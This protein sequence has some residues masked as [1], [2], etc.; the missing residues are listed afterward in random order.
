M[1]DPDDVRQA[2]PPA[3]RLPAPQ[4]PALAAYRARN[5][6]AMSGYAAIL[7]L[8]V[9]LVFVGVKL[10]YAH[11]ELNQV[12]HATAAAPAP[13]PTASTAG[14]LSLQWRTTDHPSGGNPYSNGIV[15]TY[16]GHTVNGRDALTGAVRWHYT[17]ADED[18]C[19]L[20]QQ[21][22]STI[23]FY[24]RDGNCDEVTGFVTATGV[25]K[26]YRT[27]TDNGPLSVSS[28]SNVVMITSARTVHVFDN[29]GGIDR[30]LWTAPA[31]CT[32][33]RALGG[34]SGVLFSYHCGSQNHLGLH[35]LVGGDENAKWTIDVSEPYVPV[36]AGAIVAAAAAS[37]GQVTVFSTDKGVAGKKFRLTAEARDSLATLPRSQTSVE[38]AGENSKPVE[39]IRLGTLMCF[40]A[41]GQVLWTAPSQ[42]PATLIGTDLVAAIVG[43][44]IVLRQILSGRSQ[45]VVTLSGGISV[46][47]GQVSA[48]AIGAGLLLAAKTTEFYS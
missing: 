23:A 46:G 41:R 2:T 8:V 6:R 30:W 9:I 26:Y 48:H 33:D 21:D 11:G 12:S 35:E 3:V 25:P 40:S 29:A 15:V 31:G 36:T 27:L 39:V 14:S 16:S 42:G 20:V 47:T 44:R 32:V 45:Q 4:H 19:A 37:S 22:Q 28:T 34:S 18:V 13:V 7:A 1:A 5:R 24:N 38:G 43:N 17:R 10:A